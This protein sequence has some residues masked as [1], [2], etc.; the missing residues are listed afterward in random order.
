MQTYEQNAQL[1]DPNTQYM[2]PY[3]PQAMQQSH[4]LFGRTNDLRVIQ[5]YNNEENMPESVKLDFWALA[6]KSIKLGFWTEKDYQEL[7]LHK[8]I[9][10]VGHIM[11]TPRHKYTFKTRQQ[12]NQMDFLVFADFKRGIGMEKYKINERTLQ[13]T[14]VT[15]SIQGGQVGGG[16]KGGVLAALKNFFG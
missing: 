13:A 7:F 2:D 16:K 14:S 12:M 6:S 11:S 5:E 1:V 4:D 10:K 9:I 8:N 3:F 15:Q